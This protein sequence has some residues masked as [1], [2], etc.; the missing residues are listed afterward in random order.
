MTRR[1]FTLPPR[2]G[3]RVDR[4]VSVAS[5]SGRGG[6]QTRAL[7]LPPTRTPPRRFA[8]GRGD[9]EALTLESRESRRAA[10]GWAEHVHQRAGRRQVFERVH[11]RDDVVD[12]A[13]WQAALGIDAELVLD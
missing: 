6:G 12:A 2:S 13:A 11:R 8:G 1:K 10:H 3:G 4:R 5:E 7:K 9:G